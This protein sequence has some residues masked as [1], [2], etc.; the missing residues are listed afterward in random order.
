M[1]VDSGLG[2]PITAIRVKANPATRI[3]EFVYASSTGGGGWYDKLKCG[4]RMISDGAFIR[5][6]GTDLQ[7]GEACDVATPFTRCFD[8]GDFSDQSAT[9]SCDTLATTFTMDTLDST[10]LSGAGDAITAAIQI[11]T[12]SSETTAF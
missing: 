10:V 12:A 8:A 7:P 1:T 2:N 6:E 4:L 9:T 5:A 3:F 11:A